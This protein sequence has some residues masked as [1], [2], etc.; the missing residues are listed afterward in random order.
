MG[1]T[2]SQSTST[3]D[4]S[5]DS[6]PAQSSYPQFAGSA[7][8]GRVNEYG[9]QITSPNW[10]TQFDLSIANNLQ[11]VESIDLLG[12]QDQVA[13]EC[14]VS[15]TVQTIFGD[16]SILTRFFNATATSMSLVLQ[17]NNQALYVTLP[18]VILDSDGSPNAGG[19]NQIITVGFGFKATKDDSLTNVSISMDRMEY[20]ES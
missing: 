14:T 5:I 6:A 4:A 12:P 9:S 15:G 1:M 17:R 11:A 7:N 19:K 10:V 3:L 20:F 16:N 8:V 2:G 18:R 13:G